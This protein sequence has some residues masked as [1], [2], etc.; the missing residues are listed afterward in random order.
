MRELHRRIRD[1][2]AE[3]SGVQVGL[4]PAEIDLVVGQAAQAV[5]DRRNAA[6]EHRR[7]A[8]DDDVGVEQ[9]LVGVDEVVEVGA[10]DF[11]FALEQDLHVDRQASLLLEMRL[12]R[13]EV[14]E[15][16]ALVVGR[17]A[18]VDLAVAHGGLERRRRPQVE[19][20][21]WLHVVVPVEENRR[22]AFSAEPFAVDNRVAWRFFETHVVQAN[23]LH[24]G[25]G[26]LRAAADVFL[27][28]RQGADAGDSQ[29]L[30][31]FVNVTIPVDVDVV[32][33]L[34]HVG[35]GSRLVTRHSG[36]PLALYSIHS[37][38]SR[39]ARPSCSSLIRCA[40]TLSRAIGTSA[41]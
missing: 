29:V 21:D 14:H 20:I 31:E 11:L 18:G 17:A 6:I 4:G 27:V 19:R 12:D 34:V 1:R 9:V 5:A 24:L 38:P 7:V 40:R 8:D 10:A 28:L 2:A 39:R 15:D 16:L 41:G 33:N 35:L 25:A 36:R 30:R 3:R 37:S 13:L 26:P 23:P 32:D 22:R